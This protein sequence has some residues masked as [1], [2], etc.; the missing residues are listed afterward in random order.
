MNLSSFQKKLVLIASIVGSLTVIT[1]G[2][3]SVY[4][5]IDATIVTKTYLDEKI[6]EIRKHQ[7]ISANELN[8]RLIDESLSRYY[9]KGVDTLKGKDKRRY[10]KLLL[11]ETANEDQ[12]KTLLGL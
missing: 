1:G 9:D 4:T 7:D 3:Y 8:L 5:W 10:E 2:W 6:A 12:R 11:A